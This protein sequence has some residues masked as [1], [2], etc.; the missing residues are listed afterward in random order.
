MRPEELQKIYDLLSP[1]D[2][3]EATLQQALWGN[4]YIE[5]LK[6][7]QGEPFQA[8]V[9]R[10]GLPYELPHILPGVR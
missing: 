2:M 8:Q 7:D 4:V 9:R 5:V 6:D 10:Y 3:L 1:L